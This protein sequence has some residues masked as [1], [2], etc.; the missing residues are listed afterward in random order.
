MCV[1][2]RVSVCVCVS[3]VSQAEVEYT[4]GLELLWAVRAD[5]TQVDKLREHRSVM[6]FGRA[7]AR[8][9]ASRTAMQR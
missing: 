3:R 9:Q 8:D 2:V 1:C 6:Y 7:K 5:S 4:K